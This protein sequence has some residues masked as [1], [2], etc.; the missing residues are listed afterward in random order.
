MTTVEVLCPN[1]VCAGV[2]DVNAI[3]SGEIDPIMMATMYAE[4]LLAQAE[5]Q[6]TNA[7]QMLDMNLMN[8][9]NMN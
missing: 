9:T 3:L 4:G 5:V 8:M 1:G 6:L 7:T 2:V